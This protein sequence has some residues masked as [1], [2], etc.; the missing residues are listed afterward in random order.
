MQILSQQHSAS[1]EIIMH[2]TF[3]DDVSS[4][5]QNTV[6]TLYVAH[7]AVAFCDEV[8]VCAQYVAR[9]DASTSGLKEGKAKPKLQQA[10]IL[11]QQI[12]DNFF[13]LSSRIL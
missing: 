8:D 10:H 13:I 9:T 2:W 5:L 4:H 7:K 6:H 3:D 11:L 12:Y 1:L